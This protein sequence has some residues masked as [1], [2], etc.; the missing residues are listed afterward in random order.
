M[1]T[2][3]TYS[4]LKPLSRPGYHCELVYICGHIRARARDKGSDGNPRDDIGQ[5]ESCTAWLPLTAPYPDEE[6][7]GVVMSNQP[8]LRRWI[9]HLQNRYPWHPRMITVPP[10]V[11]LEGNPLTSQE[12]LGTE[13]DKTTGQCSKGGESHFKVEAGALKA[14]LEQLVH[15]GHLKEF[16]DDEKTRA[17]ATE[18][19]TN[20]RPDRGGNEVKEAVDVKDED[21]PLGTIHVIG[22][23]NDPSLENRVWSEIRIIRQMYKVLS[24]QSLPK[25]SR[26]TEIEKEC[27]TFSKADLERVQHP[28]S[29]PLVVQL[30]IGGYDVKRILVD[31][32]SSVKVMYYD[33]FKQL[34]LPQ[35]KLKLA[36]AP[37]VG[38]NA[39]A[40]W[41]LGTVSLKI[42]AGIDQGG[43]ERDSNG[44]R[45]HRGAEGHGA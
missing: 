25:R 9:R 19:K 35:D 32:G 38:F 23:P 36:R 28:H 29:D 24:V 7:C 16:V 13:G 6:A 26:T 5:K 20:P 2:R 40:H 1:L 17:E 14:F 15:D 22:G 34:K 30:R 27:I 11:T 33:L 18:T 44:R 39:Q 41:P 12:Y 10:A 31:I 43:H 45:R 4:E 8:I 37:L 21:L 42:R 3:S